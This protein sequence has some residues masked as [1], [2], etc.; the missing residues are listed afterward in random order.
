LLAFGANGL[1]RRVRPRPLHYAATTS[2]VDLH[3]LPTDRAAVQ[4]LRGPVGPHRTV[5]WAAASAVPTSVTEGLME[6]ILKSQAADAEKDDS[7][8]VDAPTL[9]VED[10]LHPNGFD[11]KVDLHRPPSTTSGV[12]AFREALARGEVDANADPFE[13]VAGEITSLSEGIR[14]LLGSD[15]PVRLTTWVFVRGFFY[16]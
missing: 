16:L 9:V 6:S 14:K 5:H 7:A 15:H 11:F 10:P 1:A 13:L 4:L 2:R 3:S 8:W 12:A